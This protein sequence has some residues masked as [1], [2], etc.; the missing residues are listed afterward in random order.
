MMTEDIHESGTDDESIELH[1]SACPKMS[2]ALC[3]GYMQEL[4]EGVS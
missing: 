4:A 2:R 1:T 3:A